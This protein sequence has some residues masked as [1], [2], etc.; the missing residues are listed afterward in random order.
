MIP[1]VFFIFFSIS[2]VLVFKF[3][4]LY[5]DVVAVDAV[6][7]SCLGILIEDYIGESIGNFKPFSFNHLPYLI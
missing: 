7:C 2:E 4:I 5:D 1:D 3:E 6:D